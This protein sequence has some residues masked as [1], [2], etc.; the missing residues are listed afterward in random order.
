MS[1]AGI[2]YVVAVDA[3]HIR[4]SYNNNVCMSNVCIVNICIKNIWIKIS[5]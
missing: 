1:R 5:D 2:S 3:S 4:I